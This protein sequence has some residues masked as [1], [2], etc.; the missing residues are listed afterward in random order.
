[1]LDRSRKAFDFWPV[2]CIVDNHMPCRHGCRLDSPRY[3]LVNY[4]KNH[5]FTI[6]VRPLVYNRMEVNHG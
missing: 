3:Y 4:G 1:M 5:I 2:F 6:N